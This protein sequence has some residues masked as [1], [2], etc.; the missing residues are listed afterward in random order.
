MAKAIDQSVHRVIWRPLKGY[1]AGKHLVENGAHAKNIRPAGKVRPGVCLL[2]GHVCGRSGYL[3]HMDK[4]PGIEQ[5]GKAKIGQLW[6]PPL[7]NQ[8]IGGFDIEVQI[9]RM[10]NSCKP[11]NHLGHQADSVS[12]GW[13]GK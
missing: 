5:S 8:N 2:G 12:K 7:G 9:T 11:L 4:S 10:V 1:A 13:R 6:K 3:F